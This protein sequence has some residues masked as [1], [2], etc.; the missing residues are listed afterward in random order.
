MKENKIVWCRT[1]KN[2]LET[3]RDIWVREE[4]RCVGGSQSVALSFMGIEIETKIHYFFVCLKV[5][6]ILFHR[7]QSVFRDLGTWS[8]S[9][10]PAS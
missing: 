3:S 6:C 1:L 10:L 4:N 5:S 7:M 2:K 8:W 9:V